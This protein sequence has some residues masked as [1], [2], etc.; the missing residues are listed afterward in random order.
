MS[1]AS[2]VI[3]V[4]PHDDILEV[5]ARQLLGRAEALPDL[6]REVVL[7]PDLQFAPRLRR[8]LLAQAGSRGHAALLGPLI[9]T[10]DLWLTEHYPVTHAVP[11]RARRELL[12][13]E[14]LQQHPEVFAGN[15]PW[16]V[17]PALISLFDELTLHRVPV[18]GDAEHFIRQLQAAYG[19]ADSLP[20]PL[21]LEAGI[22]HR[23][24][25]AW[26]EQLGAMQLLDPGMAYLQRLAQCRD[27]LDACHLTLAGFDTFSSAE[28]DWI[29]DLLETGRADCILYRQTP[30][31]ATVIRPPWNAA[32]P[33]QRAS[34]DPVTACLDGVF[35]TTGAA[36][37]ERAR[38]LARRHPASPLAGRFALFPAGSAEQEARGIELQVRRWLL[39]QRRP[40]GI[41]T[42]DRRLARRV[43][44][45]L[46]RS[47][48][49][50][51]DSGGWA[52]ST[53][54][55]AA[56]LERWLETLEE[57]FAYR[58]L[59][60]VLKSPFSFPQED[61]AH[62]S[63]TVYRLERDIIRHEGIARGLERYQRHIDLRQERL[64]GGWPDEVY[65]ELRELLNR[66]DHAA[67][68]LRAF[69]GDSRARPLVLLDGLRRSL[70]ELGMWSAFDDDPAGQRILQEWRLLSAAARHSR[71]EMH[72]LEFRAWL[73]AA[74]ERH[75]FRPA[76]ADGPIVLVTLQQARLG[77]YAGLIIG[78]CDREH[79]PA[80][81]P[82]SPFFNDPVRV[83]L[84]LPVW[85]EHYA[86]Q[87]QRF[88]RVLESAPSVLL[89]WH[90]EDNGEPQLPGPWV[91][92]LQ[93]FHDC[94]WGEDLVDRELQALLEHPDTRV[95]GHN[96]LP[97]PPPAGYPAPSLPAGLLPDSVSVSAHEDLIECPYRFFAAH[98]LGLRP[99][100][101][102]R[103]A[104][105]KADYGERVHLCLELFHQGR[106]A[107]P[108]PFPEPVTAGNRTRAIAL[109]ETIS[110]AV[111][112]WNLEDNFEHRAWRRRWK[113]LIPAY[114][115]WQIGRAAQWRFT[116]AETKTEIRLENG[117]ILRG[118][119]DRIDTGRA[120]QAVIDY[121]TGNPPPQDDVL[122]G[123]KV[124]LPCYALLAGATPPARVEYL[125]LDGGVTSGAQL[126]GEALARLAPAVGARLVQVLD[127]IERGAPLPAWGDPTACRYC[128]MDVVCRRQAWLDPARGAAQPGNGS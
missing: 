57:D 92:A 37:A 10:P 34:P 43:R 114:I 87:L 26:H 88:R 127:A 86:L 15:D 107:W 100:E 116:T 31:A 74:L 58:P 42:E 89:T 2:R 27:T 8:Q 93:T 126:E 110:D 103:E 105:E 7:L 30:L 73:G 41:L 97:A 35:Q 96:P 70:E 117:R 53:T 11:G 66:L 90:T 9:S 106:S 123:E 14:V 50:L 44:A 95:R 28:L 79:L 113:E 120:G 49:A 84:G 54:S 1:Q 83:E 16:R 77:Q 108:G 20:E 5:T 102:I 39:E 109:L 47:G 119:L 24:W 45:L 52:L 59:L 121:K 91:E 128:D 55:A 85:P 101:S 115:D 23:L 13:V 56:A 71:I 104:L 75:D 19:I 48:I 33:P 82:G 118:R 22:V 21:G 72:W 99:K 64:P 67:E 17:A 78:A 65:A 63:A 76:T 4:A 60:D 94:G 80:A 40:I 112:A 111:F 38:D 36:L 98:G 18:P 51:Q 124:Q 32:P 12:L 69:T 61:P 81:V 46:E 62:F 25:H 125:K 6:S 3:P 68:P 122:D 29:G